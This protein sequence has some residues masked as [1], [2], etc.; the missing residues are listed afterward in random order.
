MV[1]ETA[2]TA[3]EAHVKVGTT[4]D[5]TRRMALVAAMLSPD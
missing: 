5:R 3:E 2:N 1:H 4:F